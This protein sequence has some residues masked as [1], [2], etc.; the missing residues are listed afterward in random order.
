MPDSTTTQ[1]VMDKFGEISITPQQ[2]A[3]QSALKGQREW[4]AKTQVLLQST[5]QMTGMRLGFCSKLMRYRFK[6]IKE[7]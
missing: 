2:F 6:I 1:T 5:V 4:G 3:S 7:M